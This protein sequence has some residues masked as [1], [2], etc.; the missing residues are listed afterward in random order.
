MN[1]QAQIACALALDAAV[2]DPRWFPHPARST[3]RLALWL[4]QATRSRMGDDKL[5]GCVTAA[6]VV[7]SAALAAALAMEAARRLHPWAGDVA[8]VAILWTALAPRDLADHA[9][10]VHAALERDDL[11]GARSLVGRMVGRE[12]AALDEAG[13]VRAAVESVAENTVDGV[14]GPV[15][16]AFAGGPVAA[17]AYKAVSTLDSTFGY[18]NER[19]ERFGWASARSDDVANLVPSRLTVV[20]SVLALALLRLRPV[21]ALRVCLRDGR[22][23]SS[24]NSGLAEATMAGALGVQLGG[25]LMREGRVVEH[26]TLGDAVEPLDRD[27]IRQAVLLMAV[28]T[29]MWTGMLAGLGLGRRG[30]RGFHR[31]RDAGGFDRAGGH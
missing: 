9:L 14:T 17:A 19:Y 27:H 6:A 31:L 20:A 7:G 5:A 13:V 18:R 11:D 23:H 24:P 12:V 16:Y 15:F 4:E 8:S 10:D 28:T 22:K 21:D 26:P 29:A 25:P 2:G 3:G 1:R 30:S